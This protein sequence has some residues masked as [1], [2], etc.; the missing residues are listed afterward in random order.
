MGK[1]AWLLVLGIDQIGQRCQS[2]MSNVWHKP[3]LSRLSAIAVTV[4]I[5]CWLK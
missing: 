4:T 2:V 1:E 3:V 5:M